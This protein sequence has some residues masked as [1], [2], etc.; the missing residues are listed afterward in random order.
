[1]YRLAVLADPH[2]HDVHMSYPGAP[3]GI[4][5]VRTLAETVAS[6][7][8]FNEGYMALRAALDDIVARGLKHVV[9]VGDMTDDGQISAWRA[10]MAIADEYAARDGLRFFATPGNHDLFGMRG[11]HNSKPVLRE[12]GS[13]IVL[14]SDPAHCPEDGAEVVVTRQMYCRGYPETLRC[15]W[16]LGFFPRAGDIHWETPF[17]TGAEL[18]GRTYR[19]RSEDGAIAIDMI[20]ASY[21]VEPEPGLW[22]LSLDANVYLPERAEDG[23]VR[24]VDR[25]DAGW[26]AAL[27]AKPHLL[28]WAA[29][30]AQRAATLGKALVCFSHYPAVDPLAGNHID[31]MAL[32]G[33]TSFARRV[34][35]HEVSRAFAEAGLH[36]HFSGHWH[37]NATVHTE[38]G[39]GV[40][41]VAVP[42][43]VAFPPAYKTIELDRETV[44]VRTIRLA[45]VPGHDLAYDLYRREAARTGADFGGIAS[46]AD[47]AAFLDAHLAEMVT[48]RYLPREWPQDLAQ[49]VPDVHVGDLFDLAEIAAPLDAGTWA[50]MLGGTAG[51]GPTLLQ[52]ITDWYRMRKGGQ[53]ALDYVP[54]A[55]LATYRRLARRF[56]AG[57]WPSESLQGRFQTFMRMFDRYDRAAPSL[58]FTVEFA[59]GAIQDDTGEGAGLTDLRQTGNG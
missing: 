32:L 20:D 18:E 8:V 56:E 54:Q 59:T 26:N 48:H 2:V 31:E 45:D 55:A 37:I 42:A 13:H 46:S 22:I 40:T 12:D 50:A 44:E 21:L 24:V 51:G 14:S 25:S 15:G 43:P 33:A 39:G 47:Q 5:A 9:I 36:V 29:N 41:N 19:S 57:R 7:R 34:P 23:S 52:L 1:M 53:L 58:D 3:L 30:V 28:T 4:P 11:R 10:F 49:L 17:G 16:S 38:V 27:T 6:T 35:G